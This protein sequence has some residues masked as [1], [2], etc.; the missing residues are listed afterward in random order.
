MVNITLRFRDMDIDRGNSKQIR[1][2][3]N[4]DIQKN[5]EDIMSS[6]QK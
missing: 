5:A 3:W 1:S 2:I 6:A 4:V